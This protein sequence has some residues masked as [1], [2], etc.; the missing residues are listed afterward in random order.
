MSDVSAPGS[1]AAFNFCSRWQLA[2]PRPRVWDA[3]VD[4]PSWRQWWPGLEELTPTRPGGADGV[5]QKASSCWRGPIGYQLRFSVEAVELVEHE[6]L[7]G[8]AE[9]DLS[10][11]GSWHLSDADGWTDIRLEW[12][13]DATRRWMEFL[14]PIARPV[15]VHG[16]DHVMQHGAA[17][18]A[19][20]LGV[21]LRGFHS[22]S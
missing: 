5:G 10:G 15:F 3:L 8:R 4:I 21:E 11:H 19:S 12:V 1:S 2:A 9:G 6:L 16:H 14:A 20:Y 17:G 13:V 18:L 22:T 7:R